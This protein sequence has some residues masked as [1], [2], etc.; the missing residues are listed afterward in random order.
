M[1]WRNRKPE[2]SDELSRLSGLEA[3]E[4]FNI[5]RD[6]NVEEIK[7]AY[8]QLVKIY[9]PDKSDPFMRKYNEQVIKIIN[10]AHERLISRY[11]GKK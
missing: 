1:K 7:R 3:H 5:A 6:A 10:E 2:L 9:H 4:L 11:G 8:H